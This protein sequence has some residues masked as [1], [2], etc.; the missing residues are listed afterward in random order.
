MHWLIGPV[1]EEQ[2][3]STSINS[4]HTERKPNIAMT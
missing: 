1:A 4:N 2:G 3:Y